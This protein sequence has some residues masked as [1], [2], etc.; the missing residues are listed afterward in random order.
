MSQYL[1]GSSSA[2][3]AKIAVIERMQ[4]EAE[5]GLLRGL[6]VH[7]A[8]PGE[9]G[10][11]SVYGGG[12]RFEQEDAVAEPGV[13]RNEV[14]ILSLYVR[15]VLRPAGDVKETDLV[16][17]DIGNLIGKVFHADPQLAGPFT[18]LGISSGQTD[19]SQTTDETIS[20]HAYQVRIG[21]RLVWG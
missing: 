12:T 20:I 6:E 11:R 18:W 19:Y 3:L 15:V 8:F 16:A 13:L 17:N 21:T 2:T 9:V 14:V 5:S 4:A 10:P 1:T 7:Y